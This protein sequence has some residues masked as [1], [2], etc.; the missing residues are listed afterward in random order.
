MLCTGGFGRGELGLTPFLRTMAK[1]A[2]ERGRAI[3]RWLSFFMIAY[4]ML[5]V[6]SYFGAYLLDIFMIILPE[7]PILL[8]IQT[9]VSKLPV[10]KGSVF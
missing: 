5:F 1:G 4:S 3:S 6:N 2:Q 7:I 8:V 9:T 10:W